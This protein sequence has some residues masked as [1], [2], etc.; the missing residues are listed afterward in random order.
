MNYKPG[1]IVWLK[2]LLLT[3]ETVV[4]KLPGPG[5]MQNIRFFLDVIGKWR[6][7]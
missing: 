4:Q 6:K 1:R 2:K 5:D 3:Q 7:R